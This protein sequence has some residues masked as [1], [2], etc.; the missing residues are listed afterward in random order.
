MDPFAGSG[1]VL[2]QATELGHRALGF[3]LDPLA[4]LMA[5]V[6]MTQVSDEAVED[7]AQFVLDSARE[8]HL[9]DVVLPWIDD[10]DETRSFVHYWFGVRQRRQLRRLAHVLN[11]LHMRSLTKKERLAANVLRIALSRI[12]ITKNP[13]SSLGR[14][15]SHSRPRRVI[16]HS[17][18]DVFAGFDRSQRKIRQILLSTPPLPGAVMSAGDAR[19]LKG[20]REHSIDAVL[21]SPPYLN[22]IDYMRGHRLSLVWLGYGV[23]GLRAIRSHSVGSERRPHSELDPNVETIRRSMGCLDNLP[24]RFRG[25]I[26]RYC[27]DILL[28]L[29]EVRRVLRPGGTATFVVGNSCIRGIFIR[30]ADA[31]VKAA[32]L[33]GLRQRSRRER[34]LPAQHRYLPLPANGALGKRIRTETVLTFV[35]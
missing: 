13:A 11:A 32:K 26:D 23:G 10:D 8:L 31:V 14:D 34:D 4:V 2:R 21:T 30:N 22:A 20:V 3:D 18:Y 33:V 25:I 15:A 29:C 19:K 35:H 27:E 16:S 12:I 28:T 7:M 5:K 1:T 6:W 24:S 9:D 17:P